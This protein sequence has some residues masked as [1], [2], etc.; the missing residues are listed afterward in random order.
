M[1]AGLPQHSV[2][3]LAPVR[4]W[5]RTAAQQEAADTRRDTGEQALAL[6]DAARRE[7][8]RIRAVAAEEGTATARSEAVLHSARVRRQAQET[9]LT[10]QNGLRLE[11]Q[12]QVR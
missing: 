1:M 6:L 7:A 12:R 8:D 11:L 3:A 9:V 2:T 5:L 10:R 4:A